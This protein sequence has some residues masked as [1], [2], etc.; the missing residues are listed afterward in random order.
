MIN[1]SKT[2]KKALSFEEKTVEIFFE[3]LVNSV[4]EIGQFYNF[5]AV[6]TF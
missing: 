5:S 1:L 3:S 2:W 6:I 4:N